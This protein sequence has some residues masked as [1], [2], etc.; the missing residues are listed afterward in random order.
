M[1]NEEG[2]SI[3]NE[4]SLCE[5]DCIKINKIK[6]LWKIKCRSWN[7]KADKKAKEEYKNLE[8]TDNDYYNTYIDAI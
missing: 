1:E 4:I 6:I 2:S 5:I 7:A 3:D 8:G